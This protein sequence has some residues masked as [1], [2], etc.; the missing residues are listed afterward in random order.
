MSL[1]ILVT[2]SRQ[3][4]DTPAN[5]AM[6]RAALVEALTLP[7][8]GIPV[9]VHGAQVSEDRTTGERYGSDYLCKQV[10]LALS[11]EN[12]LDV[13]LEPH[14]ADWSRL[15]R[16]AGPKRNEEMCELGADVCLAFLDDSPCVGTRHC[17]REAKRHGI[18]VRQH[19]AP[20]A[21]PQPDEEAQLGLYPT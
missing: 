17:I 2:G 3:L 18:P 10:W 11:I 14:P 12:R 21:A 16:R 15:G 1:R 4:R 6:I 8:R 20:T 19:R 7:N 13:D 9:L 5:R